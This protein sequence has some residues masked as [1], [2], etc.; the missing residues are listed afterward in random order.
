MSH[1]LHDGTVCSVY[2]YLYK[3]IIWNRIEGWAS[4]TECVQRVGLVQRVLRLVRR[5]RHDGSLLLPSE[6]ETA[7]RSRVKSIC[8]EE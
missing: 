3:N 2:A 6:L 1:T 4:R 5:R 7:F 8:E